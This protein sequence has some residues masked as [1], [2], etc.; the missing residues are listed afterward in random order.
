[1]TRHKNIINKTEAECCPYGNETIP[2]M[3][4]PLFL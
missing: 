1:M 3:S 2:N 4:V